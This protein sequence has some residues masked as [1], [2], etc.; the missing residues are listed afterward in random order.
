MCAAIAI[1]NWKQ[2]FLQETCNPTQVIQS[3]KQS[4]PY[5]LV[6]G[7]PSNRVQAFLAVDRQLLTEVDILDCPLAFM[8]AFFVFNICY[9]K[10]C[11][12]FCTVLEIALLH[13]KPNTT[14]S[15]FMSCISA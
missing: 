13:S 2:Y 11:F 15:N 4:E 1:L 9:S 10:G 14:V 5:V 6:V 7:T 12:N 3:N 8:T